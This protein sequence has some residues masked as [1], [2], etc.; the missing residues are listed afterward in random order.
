MEPQRTP[1]GQRTLEVQPDVTPRE[2]DTNRPIITIRHPAYPSTAPPLLQLRAVDR[3]WIGK[4][5]FHAYDHDTALIACSIVTGNTWGDG[6]IGLKNRKNN[7]YIKLIRERG[8]VLRTTEEYYYFV[9]K[10]STPDTKYPVVPCFEHWRFPHNDLPKP[11]KE[12]SIS[13]LPPDF[14]RLGGAPGA[15]ER[16]M[17]AEKMTKH[18]EREVARLIPKK[19][20]KWFL[21]N[22]MHEYRRSPRHPAAMDDLGNLISLPT[23]KLRRFQ[24]YMFTIVPRKT[25][26]HRVGPLVLRVFTPGERGEY[27]ALYHNRSAGCIIDM[28]K[29]YL[30]ARFA[31]LLF[32]PSVM[33]FF[34]GEGGDTAI[35]SLHHRITWRDP[36]GRLIVDHNESRNEA[37]NVTIVATPPD[38]FDNSLEIPANPIQTS[39]NSVETSVNS[40]EFPGNLLETCV[41]SVEFPGNL[42]EISS[43]PLELSSCRKRKRSETVQADEANEVKDVIVVKEAIMVKEAIDVEEAPE[44]KRLDC[45]KGK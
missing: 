19:Y 38:T 35:K 25:L 29:E 28:A 32:R 18:N 1:E 30:F 8:E 20:E 4:K 12:I 44:A 9:S 45:G 41:N 15:I 13:G 7:T 22:D 43:S 14:D 24:T 31:L 26:P 10:E 16:D 11:W 34:R 17:G 40:V 37:Q 36:M 21:L 27:V 5:P 39:V 3:T 33:P 2:S 23:A 6:Y 42:L